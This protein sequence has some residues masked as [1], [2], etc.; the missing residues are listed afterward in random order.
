MSQCGKCNKSKEH[1]FFIDKKGK[2]H[3]TCFDCRETS[4]IW[5]EKNKETV[6]LYNKNYNEKKL[7]DTE[8]NVIYARKANTNDEW[9]K[10]NSQLELAKKLSLYASNIN[11]VVKGDLKTTGGYEIKLEKEVYK[12]NA[13][14]WSVIKE[15]NNIIDKCKDQPS[16]KRVLHEKIDDIIGK[17]CCTCKRWQPLTNYNFSEDHWDKL[18]NDCKDCLKK[19]RKNSATSLLQSFRKSVVTEIARKKNDPA[20]KLRSRLGSALKNQNAIKSNKTMELVGCTI[21]FLRGYLEAKFKDDMTWENHGEWH[22]DHIKPCASFN[23]LDDEEQKKCFHYKNLQPLW[24]DEN[25]SK[26]NKYIN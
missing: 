10:F 4:R 17:N 23:L 19:Y 12:S 24:A 2:Q 15:E 13:S 18:R 6:S 25:L 26:G 22:I 5:R 1:S 16:S 3:K 20:F 7:D 9:Q 14:E 21:P 8:I 11:K